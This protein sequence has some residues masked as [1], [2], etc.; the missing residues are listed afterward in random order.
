MH[1]YFPASLASGDWKYHISGT[2]ATAE[3]NT[4]TSLLAAI[5]TARVVGTQTEGASANIYRSV[6]TITY[7]DT[8]AITE[9]GIFNTAYSASQADG[10]LMDRS[11]FNA[12]NCSSADTITFTYEL[13]AT[14]EA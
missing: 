9:H 14:A 5:G 8:C 1:F 12:V 3:A 13:T 4:H 6:A 7:T 11:K 10:V 2:D